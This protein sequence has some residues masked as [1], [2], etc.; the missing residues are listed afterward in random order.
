MRIRVEAASY[1]LD[2]KSTVAI[3]GKQVWVSEPMKTG[4]SR[5]VNIMFFEPVSG[6]LYSITNCDT[7]KCS[8]EAD[9][10]AATINNAPNGTIIIGVTFDEPTRR[11]S[12]KARLAL[13]SI[14]VDISGV[15]FRGRFAFVAQKGFSRQTQQVKSTDYTGTSVLEVSVRGRKLIQLILRLKSDVSM[16]LLVL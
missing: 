15:P 14:G 13:N 16:C 6:T 9:K 12:D 2:A 7:Y 5:G 8:E 3:D 11:M 4:K 1:A 10:L